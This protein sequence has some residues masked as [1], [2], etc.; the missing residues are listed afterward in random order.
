MTEHEHSY[1]EWD[2]TDHDAEGRVC[3][4]MKCRCGKSILVPRK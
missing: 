3:D 4:R 2:G 1:T